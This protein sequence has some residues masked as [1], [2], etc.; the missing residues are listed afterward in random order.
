MK[1]ILSTTYDDKYLFFLPIVTWCWNK[2]G[3]DVIC[4]MPYLNTS[5]ENKKV[6]L[7]N[8]LK[9]NGIIKLQYAG[10]SSV[11][12]KEATYAQ[13]S[14]LFASSL[15]YLNPYEFLTISDIDMILFKLPPTATDKFCVFGADLVPDNQL[16]MCYITALTS[17]WR[18]AFKTWDRGWQHCLDELVGSIECQDFKGNQWS[19]D[20]SEAFWRIPVNE[21]VRINRAKPGTQF[22]TKR[23]DRDDSFLLDRL[24]PDIFDYHMPRPGYE[25]KAFEQIMTVLAYFYPNEDLEW[26]RIYRNEYIKLL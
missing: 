9:I 4:F 24:S 26:I 3:V 8:D 6:D 12:E 23:L 14:R 10:F 16:P 11:K 2:L 20:Q 5:G 15:Q 25:E 7:I 1:A 19:L 13:C 18:Y 22:A 17:T 21:I